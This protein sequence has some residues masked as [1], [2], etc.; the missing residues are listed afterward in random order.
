[1]AAVGVPGG[2][3]FTV[4]FGGDL[5]GQNL[6]QII[7]TSG[8]VF[9]TAQAEG[10]TEGPEVQNVQVSLP[11]G[12]Q[13]FTLSFNGQTT[14]PLSGGASAAQ[15]QTA[16]LGLSTI[17]HNEQQDITVLGT[18]GTFKVTFNGQTTADLPFNV[19]ASG[20]TLPTDSLQNALQALTS[21]GANYN[22]RGNV[23][24]QVS[25][26]W[27]AGGFL[28]ANNSRNY[29]SVSAGFSIHYMFRAQP[30]TVT[31]PTGM[32]PY[33]GFRPFTVP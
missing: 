6:P 25:P 22:L 5:A 9:A 32:F 8:T 14:G 10:S 2:T 31:S 18:S 20:G 15:V 1:V 30:S 11:A 3:Q 27:F 19:P 13:T 4:T 26:H 21:V 7:P 33:E 24:Y 16:L 28:S 23:A 29:A 17:Q 12:G